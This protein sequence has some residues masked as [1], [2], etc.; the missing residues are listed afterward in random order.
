ML[1]V[2][3][4]LVVESVFFLDWHSCLSSWSSTDVSLSNSIFMAA[5]LLSIDVFPRKDGDGFEGIFAY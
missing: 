2:D 5:I 4:F 1:G 3:T